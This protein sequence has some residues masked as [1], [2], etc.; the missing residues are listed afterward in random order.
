MIEYYTIKAPLTTDAASITD[1]QEY[2]DTDII[3]KNNEAYFDGTT[4]FRYKSFSALK[5]TVSLNYGLDFKFQVRRRNNQ[6]IVYL[7]EYAIPDSQIVT[8]T[9]ACY[10]NFDTQVLTLFRQSTQSSKYI[11]IAI[12]LKTNFWYHLRFDKFSWYGMEGHFERFEL[13]IN[14]KHYYSPV[15]GIG[16][17]QDEL[18]T[19]VFIGQSISK[20]YGLLGKIKDFNWY[21]DIETINKTELQNQFPK[22]NA[23]F[24]FAKSNVS[25]SGE[26]G[27]GN[28]IHGSSNILSGSEVNFTGLFLT[29][30]VR[31]DILVEEKSN[32]EEAVGTV[33]NPDYLKAED[34]QKL[35]NN[36][37]VIQDV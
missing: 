23:G 17:Q 28:I 4:D 6:S 29:M 25:F 24:C 14:Y 11:N 18:L 34:V 13:L 3:F 33:D 1:E 32:L 35:F 36:R 27:T 8:G 26:V 22:V 37:E 2:S 31:Y 7:F 9:Y 15:F 20:E 30:K 21:W 12:P 5:L 19:E 16:Y 10:Y